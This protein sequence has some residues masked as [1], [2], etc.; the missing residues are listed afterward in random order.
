MNKNHLIQS[1]CNSFHSQSIPQLH[2]LPQ[3][4]FERSY[5]GE[6]SLHLEKELKHFFF[7]EEIA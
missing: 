7:S 5:I 4:F 3:I 2:Q 6:P 1:S